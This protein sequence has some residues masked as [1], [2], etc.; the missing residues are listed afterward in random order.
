MLVIESIRIFISH[1]SA[2]GKKLRI[3]DMIIFAVVH[4][5]ELSHT[6]LRDSLNRLN[7]LLIF[8]SINGA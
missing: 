4:P 7:F 6:S 3:T 1:T 8:S 5:G 2:R